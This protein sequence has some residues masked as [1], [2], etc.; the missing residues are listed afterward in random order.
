MPK[1]TSTKN[2]KMPAT[3]TQTPPAKKPFSLISDEKLLSLYAAMIK[4]RMLDERLRGAF[5]AGKLKVDSTSA[6]VDEAA[7]VGVSIDLLPDDMISPSNRESMA[8]FVKGAPLA[9]VIR[10][11]KRAARRNGPSLDAG[12]VSLIATGLA[13]ANRIQE[14]KKIAVAFLGS[15]SVASSSC[16]EALH[17]AGGNQLPILFVSHNSR[18]VDEIDF[19]AIGVPCITVDGNDVVA[20][21]RL[22]CEAITHA[23]KGNG[24]TL[25]ECKTFALDNGKLPAR[26]KHTKPGKTKNDSSIDPIVNMET[27]LE[28]K[29]LF[30]KELNGEIIAAFTRDLNAALK[31]ADK[32]P[33]AGK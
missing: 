28:S 7:L 27:Y 25:I 32:P 9:A 29:G 26:G 1:A 30:R 5:A 6:A 31:A 8:R 19:K 10:D 13:L 4:C 2:R 24:P 15:E 22:A 12:S 16:R 3:A 21:Y 33:L 18:Q 14:T 11:A 17:F 23:R 20:V